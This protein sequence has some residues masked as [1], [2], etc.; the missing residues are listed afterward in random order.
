MAK[1]GKKK[2]KHGKSRK[3]SAAAKRAYKKSGLYKYNQRQKRKRGGKKRKSYGKKKGKKRSGG[4]KTKSYTKRTAAPMKRDAAYA[5][6]IAQGKSPEA[7]AKI[8]DRYAR[9]KST[10]VSQYF[11]KEAAA[12]KTASEKKHMDDFWKA[13]GHAGREH[14]RVTH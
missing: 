8:A 10:K 3:R 4:K 1:G 2:K 6:L 13:L 14:H 5:R 9:I 11:I 12:A 7:A